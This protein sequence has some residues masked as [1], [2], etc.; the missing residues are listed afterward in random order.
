MAIRSFST[1]VSNHVRI[2]GY[3]MATANPTAVVNNAP[4]CPRKLMEGRLAVCR[5]IADP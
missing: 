1:V 5:R 4:R 2:T 3:G